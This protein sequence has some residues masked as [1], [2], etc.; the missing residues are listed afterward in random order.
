MAAAVLGLLITTG[1]T[2][3]GLEVS[4]ASGNDTLAQAQ[5]I[6]GSFSY[7]SQPEIENS[8]SFAHVTVLGTGD[9]TFDYYSFTVAAE[10]VGATALLDIDGAM[11]S[12]DSKLTL[13][14]AAGT[15]LRVADDRG[16]ADLPGS[17]SPLDAFMATSFASPGTFVVRVSRYG[18]AEDLPVPTGA[19]YRLHVSVPGHAAVDVVPPVLTLPSSVNRNITDPDASVVATWSASADDWFH[20]PV[21]VTC[22]PASGSSFPRGTT[23]VTCSA[24]DEAGNVGT[25]SFPVNVTYWPP[26]EFFDVPDTLVVDAAWPDGTVVDYVP[27]TA[28]DVLFSTVPVTCEPGP[29]T[30]F[31]I[32]TTTVT[33]RATGQFQSEGTVAFDVVVRSPFDGFF[34]P[35]DN[36]GVANTVKAG[37]GVPVK[38]SLAGDRGLD[39]LAPGSPSSRQVDCDSGARQDAVELTVTSGS[40][41]LTYDAVKDE[42]NYAWKTSAA[43]AGTCRELTVTLD[44]GTVHTAL[45]D[46]TR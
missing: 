21:P 13:Y 11:P 22:N 7:E 20:G 29:G 8:T 44:D 3:S 23:T 43:W 19:T 36:N 26:P 6:D 5:D 34:A 16:G 28:M 25:G 2:A 12:F 33:C 24:V 46:F 15:V 41:G 1:G 30:L 45:F 17:V 32:G 37:R 38:F 10:S 39:I 42:Y 9:G 4:S 14:D 35:V 27:P 18:G 40:S 31:P